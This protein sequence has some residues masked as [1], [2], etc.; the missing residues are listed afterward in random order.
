[1]T[2]S[3]PLRAFRV[4]G[5]LLTS[6]Y[7]R[8]SSILSVSVT[9]LRLQLDRF[10]ILVFDGF[11]SKERL[12]LLYDELLENLVTSSVRDITDSPRRI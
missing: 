9:C 7:V 3:F 6:L 2:A 5:S 8:K 11:L 10:L 1:M 4:A 12:S